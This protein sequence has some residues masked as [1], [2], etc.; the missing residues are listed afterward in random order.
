MIK[1]N[2]EEIIKEVERYMRGES[3]QGAEGKRL[4]VSKTSF[5]SWI[6]RYETFG[7]E[8]FQHTRNRQYSSELKYAAVRDYYNTQRRQ[9]RLDCQTPASYR[10][11][12]EA[13]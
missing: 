4:G 7:S 12:L 5:R 11:L 3:T 6:R 10:S 8:G 1:R 13:A 2:A 9:H